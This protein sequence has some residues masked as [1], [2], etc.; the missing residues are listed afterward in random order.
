MRDEARRI[1]A[2]IAKL[3]EVLAGLGVGVICDPGLDLHQC[4]RVSDRRF[5]I[6][7]LSGFVMTRLASGPR[8]S[9]EALSFHD[10]VAGIRAAFA[11]FLA[12]VTGFTAISW[13]TCARS[14]QR[15]CQNW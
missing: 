4:P 12:G 13:I 7:L 5:Y 14:R 10:T 15:L 8:R 1:A 6:P 2:N 3:P 9:V 11:D